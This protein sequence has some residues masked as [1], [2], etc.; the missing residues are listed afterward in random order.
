MLVKKGEYIGFCIHRRSYL[1]GSPDEPYSFVI[2][3]DM[4]RDSPMYERCR[5][6][7]IGKLVFSVIVVVVVLALTR[8]IKSVVSGQA[9]V[10]LELRNTPGKNTNQRW[11]THISQLTQFMPPPE[12]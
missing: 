10:S 7:G 4:I 5:I 1:L 12:T 2:Y 8:I 11:Y 3:G 6:L 9:P